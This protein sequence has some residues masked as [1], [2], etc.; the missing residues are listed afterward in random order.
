MSARPE[1]D[2]RHP[3]LSDPRRDRKRLVQHLYQSGRPEQPW[4]LARW[5]GDGATPDDVWRIVADSE[6]LD[7]WTKPGTRTVYIVHRGKED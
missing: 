4:K 2:D 7:T 1:H 5:L 3:R 6:A